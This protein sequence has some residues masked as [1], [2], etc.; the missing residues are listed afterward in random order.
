[1]PAGEWRGPQRREFSAA[2]PELMR[3]VIGQVYG[4]IALTTRNRNGTTGFALTHVD[5]GSLPP[6]A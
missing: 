2:D 4:G 3:W 6:T 1:M 5:A